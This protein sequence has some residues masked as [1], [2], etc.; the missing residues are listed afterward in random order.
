M[1]L[2]TALY[3]P[4]KLSFTRIISTLI[5]ILSFYQGFSFCSPSDSLGSQAPC[6][7][8]KDSSSLYI[9]DDTILIGCSTQGL[10]LFF[11]GCGEQEV[12]WTDSYIGDS[13][14]INSYIQLFP[15]C[16]LG[17]P[18]DSSK[19]ATVVLFDDPPITP[20][21]IINRSNAD[22]CQNSIV[23][24]TSNCL[25]NDSYETI[26]Q[27]SISVNPLLASTNGVY[28]AKCKNQCG[29][30]EPSYTNVLN[31]EVEVNYS[32]SATRFNICQGEETVLK[33][34]SDLPGGS[35][36]LSAN[37]IIWSNGISGD[38]MI[39]V[40]EPSKYSF[41][42][43]PFCTDT[44]KSD[45]IE[46]FAGVDKPSIQA[47][48][49][50]G[51]LFNDYFIQICSVDSVMFIASNCSGTI[52]WNTGVSGDTIYVRNSG[53]YSA[54][55]ANSCG[56]SENSDQIELLNQ[57]CSLSRPILNPNSV[58]SYCE[59]D[60]ALLILKC[61]LGLINWKSPAL[62]GLGDTVTLPLPS[63]FYE[64]SCTDNGQESSSLL[65]E[66]TKSP[67]VNTPQLTSDKITICN[68]EFATLN[69]TGCNGFLTWFGDGIIGID[70]TQLIVDKAGS[71]YVTCTGT[72]GI[73]RSSSII[74][75]EK[76]NTPNAP[77][78]SA[79]RT[80]L[81]EG[82][83]ATIVASGC[84]SGLT[85]N[86]LQ[87]TPSIITETAGVYFALCSNICG[88]SQKSNEVEIVKYNSPEDAVVVQE[89]I[90][91]ANGSRSIL[92]KALN[93]TF[94]TRWSTGLTALSIKVS[95]GN[96]SASCVNPCGFGNE[97]FFE[98]KFSALNC[99]EVCI[100]IYITKKP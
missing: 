25:G 43:V 47:F 16:G 39:T 4:T 52:N 98:A 57:V 20:T 51:N 88:E 86:T 31:A 38:S 82:Q 9:K 81:C 53:V 24:L 44:I 78:V 56:T 62:F 1:H 91:E 18:L 93:C 10:T 46:I 3:M 84:N 65:V 50:L 99:K 96:Y 19:F 90:T 21:V 13:I 22:L 2:T 11:S 70:P 55:C 29:I 61:E 8:L 27:D 40:T 66:V 87:S 6:L 32:I 59:G 48:D 36:D 73:T 80:T 60:S 85:W 72:C 71:Y 75:I 94:Q 14:V 97:I 17:L 79:N 74:Q 69:A 95:P 26:W 45:T 7:Y 33:A 100:P 12:Q 30:G 89:T 77:V 23:M 41:Q 58:L 5:L 34:L 83:S 49:K 28:K 35:I 92:L 64:V 67:Q 76:N 68:A 42:I 54:T 37:Q 15:R 63:G